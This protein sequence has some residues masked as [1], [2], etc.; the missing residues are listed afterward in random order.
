M[1]QYCYDKVNILFFYSNPQ[2]HIRDYIYHSNHN[3]DDKTIETLKIFSGS[4]WLQSPQDAQCLWWLIGQASCGT[5]KFCEGGV[6]A[7]PPSDRTYNCSHNKSCDWSCSDHNMMEAPPQHC[8]ACNFCKESHVIEWENCTM[9]ISPQVSK[10]PR[11]FTCCTKPPIIL[12]LVPT[13]WHLPI[14]PL[15]HE[16]AITPLRIWITHSSCHCSCSCSCLLSDNHH[17][18]DHQD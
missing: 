3:F 5:N 11:T 13:D 8:N 4:F 17:H 9:K 1:F 7:A 16:V 2:N 18:D 10:P 15:Q 6:D 12:T 14:I